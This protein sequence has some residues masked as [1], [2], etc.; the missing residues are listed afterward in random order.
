MLKRLLWAAAFVG[1]V[2]GMYF[3]VAIGLE[4]DEVAGCKF[5]QWMA[6]GKAEPEMDISSNVVFRTIENS[7][8]ADFRGLDRAWSHVC[9][10]SFY[11]PGSPYLSRRDAHWSGP[12]GP[13]AQGCWKGADPEN[14]TLLLANR[15]TGE[16]EAYRVPVPSEFRIR[17]QGR[18]VDTDYRIAELPESESQCAETAM[19][20]ATCKQGA[21]GSSEACL[22]V[23]RQ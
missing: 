22:L 1:L 9:L 16:T 23:F 7:I 18:F 3:A 14:L 10:T 19:A 11:Q 6:G 17:F 12:V 8:S 21:S 13:R 4:N 5:K 2:S 20:V 15:R